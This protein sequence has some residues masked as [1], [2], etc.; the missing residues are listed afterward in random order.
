[1]IHLK[2]ILNLLPTYDTSVK[3]SYELAAILDLF[4]FAPTDFLVSFDVKSFYTKVPVQEMLIIVERRL[5]KLEMNNPELLKETTTLSVRAIM[6]LL[7][8]ALSDCYFIFAG[9]LY[10]QCDGLPMGG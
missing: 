9:H 7:H 6:D 1:M 3:H 5:T 10:H 2:N 8:F 4:C